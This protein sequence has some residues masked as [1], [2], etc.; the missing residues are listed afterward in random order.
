MAELRTLLYDFTEKCFSGR[1]KIW[2]M[3]LYE[4]QE[5]TE[6]ERPDLIARLENGQVDFSQFMEAMMETMERNI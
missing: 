6:R 4:Q 5:R 3:S 2:P 1:L